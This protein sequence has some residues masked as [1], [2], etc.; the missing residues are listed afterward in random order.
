MLSEYI[1]QVVLTTLLELYKLQQAG[2]GKMESQAVVSCM[3][4]K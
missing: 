3:Q 4:T 2:M 1:L